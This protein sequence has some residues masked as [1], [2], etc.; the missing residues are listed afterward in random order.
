MTGNCG[1]GTPDL[2]RLPTASNSTVA[3]TGIGR[4]LRLAEAIPVRENPCVNVTATA[5]QC[6]SVVTA[7]AARG[8]T[9]RSE[10][11]RYPMSFGQ[12]SV[13]AVPVLP[14]IPIR[15]DRFSGNRWPP[16]WRAGTALNVDDDSHHRGDCGIGRSRCGSAAEPLQQGKR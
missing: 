16:Y 1:A 10:S 15:G 2:A 13:T 5:T 7:V 3:D 6:A 9:G 14:G 12:R 8:Y 4:T 11:P